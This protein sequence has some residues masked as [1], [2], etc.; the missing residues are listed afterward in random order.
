MIMRARRDGN[1]IVLALEGHLDFESTHQFKETC[2]GL[3]K[4][5]NTQR[6]ILNLEKLKFVGSS[7]INQFIKVLK[8]FNSKRDRPKMC[9]VSS[10]FS[11]L[12]RIYQTKRNPFEIYEDEQVAV[13]SFVLPEIKRPLKTRRLNH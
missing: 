3:M 13:Q 2:F 7:G 1:V 5:A 4:R 10:E 9:G 6:I 12:F 8:E 11:R